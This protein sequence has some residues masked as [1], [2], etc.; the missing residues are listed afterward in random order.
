[1]SD[2]S[3]IKVALAPGLYIIATPLGNARDITLRALDVLANADAI[4]CEDTRVSGK[5]TA[6]YGIS[7]PRL[8]YH[9]HNA[10]RIRPKILQRLAAGEA[11]ALISDAGTP[12]VSD[13]G[14]PLVRAARAEGHSVFAVPGASAPVAA[15]SIA[16]LA[17][18]RFTFAGFLPPKTGARQQALQ[19]LATAPGTLIIFE[20][21]N[22]LAALMQDVAA[23]TPQREVV[24][25]RELT[26]KF[27]E[28]ISGTACELADRLAVSPVKG[29][30]VVLL[31]APPPARL[32]EAALD[33]ALSDALASHSLRDA[34]QIIMAVYG[35]PKKSVYARALALSEALSDGRDMQPDKQA[36]KE[37]GNEQEKHTEKDTSQSG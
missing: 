36:E 28:V 32:D 29:E 33:A 11:L 16:G 26:K 23:T 25:A 9:E 20:S 35:L 5:L 21:A 2:W 6:R 1:M 24:I 31:A 18:D 3:P 37:T 15:L 7:T 8:A 13:P 19:E 17:T 14:L 30:C 10:Q 27:E 4:F 12:L 34:V 22:R